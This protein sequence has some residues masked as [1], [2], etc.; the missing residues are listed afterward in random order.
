MNGNED[1]QRWDPGSGLERLIKDDREAVLF[2]HLKWVYQQRRDE[3]CDVAIVYGAAHVIPTV[4]FL[5]QAL[6]YVPSSG[7]WITVFT[8]E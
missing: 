4:T 3:R 1:V 5:T 7:E 2:S 6:G 8:Y